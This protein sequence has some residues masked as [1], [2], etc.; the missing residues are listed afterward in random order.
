MSL[1][2]SRGM[3]QSLAKAIVDRA[4]QIAALIQISEHCECPLAVRGHFSE[5]TNALV[6]AGLREIFSPLNPIAAWAA[7]LTGADQMV[8]LDVAPEEVAS[9]FP[10]NVE[11]VS[12]NKTFSQ[13][14]ADQVNR[15]YA[16]YA[17]PV[18]RSKS[19]QEQ[20]EDLNP[21]SA[22][23][24]PTSVVTSGSAL[25]DQ[26]KLTAA[27]LKLAFP[28]Y[29][30]VLDSGEFIVRLS[31][32]MKL[33]LRTFAPNLSLAL[34]SKE[35]IKAVVASSIMGSTPSYIKTMQQRA[36]STFN[37]R[38][39]VQVRMLKTSL[40]SRGIA[41]VAKAFQKDGVFSVELFNSVVSALK[42]PASINTAL[43]P[44]LKNAML[45]SAIQKAESVVSALSAVNEEQ[46]PSQ[47]E[48]VNRFDQVFAVQRLEDVLARY[49]EAQVDRPHEPRHQHEQGVAP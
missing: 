8:K 14:L 17:S 47:A 11:D 25:A 33:A 48:A 45:A 27:T 46:N 36:P 24:S 40:E 6:P 5:Q 49:N 19:V 28:H 44:Q 34:M 18:V 39:E 43:Q 26:Q 20:V 2:L 31:Q 41:E 16:K 42:F 12:R 3:S 4:P 1:L 32:Q 21:V 10:I 13:T 37:T 22:G 9:R 23:Q 15:V 38:N 35:Q 30:E 29:K 7:Q